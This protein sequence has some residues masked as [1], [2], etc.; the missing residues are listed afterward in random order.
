MF[1][2]GFADELVG[3]EAAQGLQPPCV[4]VGIDEELEVAAELVVAAVVVATRCGILQ[5]PVHP[6]DLPV[7]PG[8]RGS[9]AAMRRVAFSC[10]STKANFEVLS[11]ATK[12]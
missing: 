2:P 10:S 12:R 6:P 3:G 7:G 8:M 5:R 4:V 9:G 11:M 1:C